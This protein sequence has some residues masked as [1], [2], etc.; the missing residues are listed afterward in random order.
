MLYTTCRMHYDDEFPECSSAVTWPALTMPPLQCMW[1]AT[2]HR[3]HFS[4]FRR[5]DLSFRFFALHLPTSTRNSWFRPLYELMG[6]CTIFCPMQICLCRAHKLRCGTMW[7]VLAVAVW[8]N[9][10]WHISQVVS[11]E[12]MPTSPPHNG[13]HKHFF[14]R[15]RAFSICARNGFVGSSQLFLIRRRI[16]AF[17]YHDTATQL[18][19]HTFHKWHGKIAKRICKQRASN[20]RRVRFGRF[21][22]YLH[23]LFRLWAL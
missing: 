16:F 9:L 15:I 5:V 1:M 12:N 11:N 4:L 2:I 3:I 8:R 22:Y 7:R 14:L 23:I 21:I 13:M 10:K 17:A 20:K 6:H 18:T 19:L